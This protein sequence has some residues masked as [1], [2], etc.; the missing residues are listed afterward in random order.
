MRKHE[1]EQTGR[2]A[3][4]T[5]IPDRTNQDAK[6]NQIIRLHNAGRSPD[7]IARVCYAGTLP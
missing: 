4:N 6:H 2:T 1:E 3:K 7:E 5:T